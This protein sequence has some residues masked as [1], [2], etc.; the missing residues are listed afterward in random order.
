MRQMRVR[1][2]SARYQRIT[3]GTKSTLSCVTVKLSAYS[4]GAPVLR[5]NVLR[6][7]GERFAHRMQIAFAFDS[8]DR[9]TVAPGL[10]HIDVDRDLAQP[11]FGDERSRNCGCSSSVW[12]CVISIGTSPT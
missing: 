12:P 5:A 10:R 3:S 9:I 8:A 1:S 2:G 6:E 11:A 4:S 7:T